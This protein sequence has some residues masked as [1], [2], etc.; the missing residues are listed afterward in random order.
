MP[1]KVSILVIDGGTACRTCSSPLP[2]TF[3]VNAS[4]F[5]GNYDHVLDID[6]TVTT[7]VA[8]GSAPAMLLPLTRTPAAQTSHQPYNL[9]NRPLVMMIGGVNLFLSASPRPT[10]QIVRRRRALCGAAVI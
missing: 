5:F 10:P 1:R 3:T 4:G 9:V 8:N 7:L 2:A 6:S